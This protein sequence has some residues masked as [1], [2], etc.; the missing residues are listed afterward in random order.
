MNT[1]AK[2]INGMV[3][4]ILSGVLLGGFYEQFY[5]HL[6]PC[7][8]CLLQR[9]CMIGIAC[10]EL[11]NLR[12]GIQISHYAISYLSAVLGAS[13]SI[14]QILLNIDPEKIPFGIPMFGLNLYTW[15]FIV[16][17]C[18]IFGTTLLLFFYRPPS[19]ERPHLSLEWISVIAFTLIFLITLV[20]VVY[21]F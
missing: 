16:F 7:P 15:A 3:I 10:S 19:K 11:L 21:S 5:Y 13:V 9:L 2:Y 6:E 17:V 4:L 8:L 12:F 14:R 18:S 1:F 20:N